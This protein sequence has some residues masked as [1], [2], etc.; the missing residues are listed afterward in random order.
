MKRMS[1]RGV[2]ALALGLLGGALAALA[3]EGRPA[4]AAAVIQSCPFTAMLPGTYILTRDLTCPPPAAITVTADG[5][6]LVLGGRTLT[7]NGGGDGIVAAGSEDDPVTGLRV[8]SGTVTGFDDGLVLG[9]T[10]GAQISGVT[11]TDSA[12]DGIAV[13]N[14]PG[15]RVVGN[16]AVRNGGD[17]IDV[18]GCNGCLVIGNRIVENVDTGIEAESLTGAWIAANIVTG[19]GDDGIDLQ[20]E[21]ADGNRVLGNK[22][23]G[24]D[25]NGIVVDAGSTGNHF[26][27]NQA[28]GNPGLDLEDVNLPANPCP[29][30]WRGNVFVTDNEGNGPGA[31][32]IR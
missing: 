9:N 19:N 31:G 25:D 15:T 12:D 7:G 18:G 16:T 21:E 20:G 11:A 2:A 27:G 26:D 3:V 30:T 28:T 8:L 23:I 10:P 24:N 29:N 17:G 32:C 22:T 4:A 1:T 6:R 14:S 5:V 13:R